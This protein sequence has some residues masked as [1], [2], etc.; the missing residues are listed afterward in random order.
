[1]IWFECIGHRGGGGLVYK[2]RF[3]CSVFPCSIFYLNS[4]ANY[5]WFQRIENLRCTS[6]VRYCLVQ[7][8]IFPTRI[9]GPEIGGF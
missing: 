5:Q 8:K 6:T 9:G 4:T 2:Q 7:F 3:S 1:M